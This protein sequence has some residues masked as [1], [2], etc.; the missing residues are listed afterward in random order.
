[1]RSR[2]VLPLALLFAACASINQPPT[3][4]RPAIEVRQSSALFFGSSS[5]APLNLELEITNPSKEPIVLRRI[6]I[7]AGPGMVQFSIYPAERMVRETIEPGQSKVINMTATAYTNLSR[8][9]PTEPLG[10]RTTLDYEVGGKRHQEL[11]VLLNVA[12]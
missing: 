9:D 12:Q 6:R 7:Q 1:M 4:G 3:P 5:T 8:L 2:L 11:Y 10:V